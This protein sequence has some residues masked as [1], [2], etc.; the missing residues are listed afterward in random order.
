MHD[1]DSDMSGNRPRHISVLSWNTLAPV[2]FREAASRSGRRARGATEAD[3]P[4]AFVA[5]HRQICC[6][7]AASSADIICLQEH[8]F[9]PQLVDLYKDHLGSQGYRYEA[10]QRTAWNCDGRSEDGVALLV[11]SASFE[12]ESRH[13]VCFHDYGIPQDRVALILSLRDT[14]DGQSGPESRRLAVLCTHLTYP[15]STYDEEAREAQISACLDA[16]RH[17]P[18]GT[19][20]IV[21]GDLNGPASDNVGRRLLAQGLQCAWSDVHGRL[22]EITHLDHRGRH[23]AS[24][25]VWSRGPLAAERA[26]LLPECAPDSARLTRPAIGAVHSDTDPTVLEDFGQLSDHRPLLVSFSW[27][28]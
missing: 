24:D 5:R 18:E 19:P 20:V 26:V 15:H 8:W 25:H 1:I 22:C 6:A 3:Q 23:F 28:R 13:D 16:L 27:P 14:R 10:L 4:K 21:A 7:L 17:L 11:K 2:Y 9:S 12:I